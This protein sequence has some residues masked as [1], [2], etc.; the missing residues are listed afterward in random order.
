MKRIVKLGSIV[1]VGLLCV[2][3]VGIAANVPV[4][5][6]TK[7]NYQF[8]I[9]DEI[10]KLPQYL[11]VMSKNNATYVPLRF[12]SETIGLEVDYK[13][14]TVVINSEEYKASTSELSRK[15]IE[16]LE[17]ELKKLKDE[18]ELLKKEIAS[19]E[20]ISAYRPIP[21]YAEDARGFKLSI[22]D[23]SKY[24]S[25][26]VELS[27]SISNSDV[28][29]T[30]YLDPFATKVVV[31]GKEYKVTTDEGANLSTNLGPDKSLTGRVVVDGLDTTKLKGVAKFYYK[32]NN[33][34]E[35]S[36]DIFFDSTK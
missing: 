3:G 10:V 26:K 18:N 24:D 36:F 6:V 28:Y 17:V 29:N 33:V 20:N 1:M 9:N 35:K 8:L 15:K 23:V 5:G 30:Y 14:G 21:T 19:S 34:D 12:L 27:L 32:V 13:P 16:D 11:D 7:V 31:N 22:L 4:N 25:N 2:T